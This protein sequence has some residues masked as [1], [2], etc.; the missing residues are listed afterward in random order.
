MSHTDCQIGFT[1]N[2][3]KCI[4]KQTMRLIT[5]RNI[6]ILSFALLI[7]W[8]V[9]QTLYSN[10]EIELT[11]T[12]IPISANVDLTLQKIKYTR[13]DAGKSQW[14]LISKSA[15]HLEDGTILVKN[16]QIVFF[17]QNKGDIKLTAD[18]GKLMAN[19]GTVSVSSNVVVNYPSGQTLQTDF[20]EH[21]ENSN[22]L[23]T[24]EVVHIFTDDYTVTGRGMKVDIVK[25]TLI[26]LH[27]VKAQFGGFSNHATSLSPR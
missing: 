14:T 23:Q 24:D 6:T 20:L 19:N 18:R 9:L 15:D 1:C 11:T 21:K 4:Y 27:D 2:G 13:T 17:D 7:I 3:T 12:N 8:L 5:I 10:D 22:I 25:R 16:V 26:L